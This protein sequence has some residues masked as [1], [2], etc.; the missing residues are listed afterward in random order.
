MPSGPT[1]AA[2]FAMYV[3]CAPSVTPAIASPVPGFRVGT[4]IFVRSS[5]S[6]TAVRYT[7]T[8][9]SSA[10][11]DALAVS[12]ADRERRAE[13]GEERRKVVRGVVDADVAADGAAVADLDV[14][15]R[16]GDLGQDRPR[17]LDLGRR[18]R[19][20]CS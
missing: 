13:R 19:P 20:A 16:R 6:P 1:V 9:N 7:P 8:K 5:P 10:G 12:A 2:A 14:G 18:D 3:P 15:D 11:D 17:H 4:E